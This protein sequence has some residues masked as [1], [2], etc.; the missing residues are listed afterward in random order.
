[1]E[2]FSCGLRVGSLKFLLERD[3]TYV[4]VSLE[5]SVRKKENE[6]NNELPCT[7]DQWCHELTPIVLHAGGTLSLYGLCIED[8]C[9][10]LFILLREAVEIHSLKKISIRCY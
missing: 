4:K 6:N 1:M 5:K 2:Y 3:C 9:T 10:L 7:L 8:A